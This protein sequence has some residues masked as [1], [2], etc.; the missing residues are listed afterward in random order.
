MVLKMKDRVIGCRIVLCLFLAPVVT[1]CPAQHT[2]DCETHI[3]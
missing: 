1:L 2:E 3:H